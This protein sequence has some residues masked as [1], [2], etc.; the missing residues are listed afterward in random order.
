MLHPDK[1]TFLV[2]WPK[3]FTTFLGVIEFIAFVMF[4]LTELCSVAANFWVTNVFAGGWCGII[5]LIHAIFLFIAGLCSPGPSSAFRAALLTILMFIACGALIAFDIA[6]IVQPSTC[7]LTSS[8]SDN[9]YSSSV[10]SYSFRSSFFSVFNSW[11]PFKTY[12]QNQVKLLCQAIQLGLAGLCII[13]GIVYLVIYFECLRRLKKH[14]Q[15]GNN[16]SPNPQNY[17]SIN[18]N[19]VSPLPNGPRSALTPPPVTPGQIFPSSI[20]Q[21]VYMVPP[22]PQQVYVTPTSINPAQPIYYHPPPPAVQ[23]IYYP[24]PPPPQP[25]M[26][27]APVPFSAQAQATVRPWYAHKNY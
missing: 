18:A 26:Y 22:P 2:I 9:A 17:N 10:F 4:I 1:T 25:Q 20:Q 19:S 11:D 13:V 15:L 3:C 27:R 21:P 8:C 14:Q 5:V 16:S 23:P 6:F 24:P 7:I 12:T